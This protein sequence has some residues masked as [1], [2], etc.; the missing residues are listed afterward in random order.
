MAS[1][2]GQTAAPS[3]RLLLKMEET[4]WTC[5]CGMRSCAFLASGLA[6]RPNAMWGG[7][8]FAHERRGLRDIM[9]LFHNKPWKNYT[10]MDDGE[11][12][13]LHSHA[14]QIWC[15]LTS[16]YDKLLQTVMWIQCA[17][18]AETRVWLVLRWTTFAHKCFFRTVYRASLFF[19]TKTR[20]KKSAI[21]TIACQMNL[22]HCICFLNMLPRF[23]PLSWLQLMYEEQVAKP[24]GLK[25]LHTVLS[26]LHSPAMPKS[27][28][29]TPTSNVLLMLL[30]CLF[31]SK[32]INPQASSSKNGP[33]A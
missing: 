5:L 22:V 30:Q 25:P 6:L 4:L 33:L 29:K 27:T 23:S 1:D 15:G 31:K 18:N 2:R 14:G 16:D 3:S 26:I 17:I 19:V 28:H 21:A 32:M 12:L 20:N 9:N 24:L 13:T 10:W 7:G 11:V 8:H